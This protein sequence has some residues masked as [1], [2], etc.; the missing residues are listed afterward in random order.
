MTVSLARSTPAGR[1]G[2]WA[3][4]PHMSDVLLDRDTDERAVLGPRTV[5]VLDVLV[6]EQLVQ[7]EP[8][9]ARPL[10]DPAVG[11]GVA[12]VVEPLVAVELGE[13]VVGLEGAVLVGGLRPRHVERGGDVPATLG[14]LLRQ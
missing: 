12:T 5:V 11:N 8:G 14:L 4:A 10:A 9:V 2:D 1:V 7:R 3:G 13:F 6:A